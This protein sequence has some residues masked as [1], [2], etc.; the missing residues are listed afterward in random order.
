MD[1]D[2]GDRIYGTN[3]SWCKPEGDQGATT[4]EQNRKCITR[5]KL[6]MVKARSS[7]DIIECCAE[8]AFEFKIMMEINIG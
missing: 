7:Y 4:K 1:T 8:G 5:V 6:Q 3:N 2:Q